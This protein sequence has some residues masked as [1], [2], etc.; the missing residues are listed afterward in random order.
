MG[1]EVSL[2]FVENH[3]TLSAQVDVG[4]GLID[5]EME[6]MPYLYVVGVDETGIADIGVVL[7][8]ELTAEIIEKI[9]TIRE[10]V[11]E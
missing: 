10:Y 11:Y 8:L 2:D 1:R 4:L 9:E 7:R 6:K 5:D 3:Q